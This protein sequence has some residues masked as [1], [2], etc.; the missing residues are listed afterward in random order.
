MGG[1]AINL[2]TTWIM[3]ILR[4]SLA[5]D[6]NRSLSHAAITG[7]EAALVTMTKER[8]QGLASTRFI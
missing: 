5:Q 7:F 3:P 4:S 6:I 1:Q 2:E 8:I